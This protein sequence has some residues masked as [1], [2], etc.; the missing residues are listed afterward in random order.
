MKLRTFVDYGQPLNGDNRYV[1]HF[2]KD[3]IP[4]AHCSGR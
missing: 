4:E 3:E 1:I 2:S